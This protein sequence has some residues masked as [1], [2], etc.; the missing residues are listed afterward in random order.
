[1]EDITLQDKIYNELS[2][3]NFSRNSV[4]F[5]YL[6]FAIYLVSKDKRNIRN[7]RNGVYTQIAKIY[8]TKPEN[9]MWGITKT[10]KMMYLNTDEKIIENYFNLY[11]DTKPSAKEFIIYIAYRVTRDL[12]FALF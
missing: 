12:S 1:M 9:V 5:Q 6:I 3:F 10:I 2:N 7:F 4:A 11:D 8:N